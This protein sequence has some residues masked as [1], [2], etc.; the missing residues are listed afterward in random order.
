M[1]ERP[2]SRVRYRSIG[3]NIGAASASFPFVFVAGELLVLL[4]FVP[5][6]ITSSDSSADWGCDSS[7]EWSVMLLLAAAVALALVFP[8]RALRR[9]VVLT[10]RLYSQR[11]T[12]FTRHVPLS[13]VTA[14]SCPLRWNAERG[15]FEALPRERTLWLDD[16]RSLKVSTDR[17]APMMAARLDE[18]VL[19]DTSDAQDGEA[20][21]HP[22]GRGDRWLALV[23]C[24]LCVV[25]LASA[26][27]IAR[28]LPDLD[29][30]AADRARTEVAAASV[31]SVRWDKGSATSHVG[32]VFSVGDKLAQAEVCRPGR[33]ALSVE[34]TVNVEFSPEDP[35]N[36]A[37]LDRPA[38]HESATWILLFVY[39]VIGLAALLGGIVIAV[40]LTRKARLA[41]RLGHRR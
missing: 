41:A 17:W 3:R 29:V 7:I 23:L 13:R 35:R 32:V 26:F 27:A 25:V 16:G 36:A 30:A 14:I 31:V 20:P 34:D 21:I 19:A 37:F 40:H 4:A 28:F 2:R 8:V 11:A 5:V 18:R 33:I 9:R 12:F 1:N 39:A 22:C 38:I 10:D 15:K 24:L 6:I